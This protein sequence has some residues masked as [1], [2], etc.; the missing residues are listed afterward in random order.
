MEANPQGI[1]VLARRGMHCPACAMPPFATPAEAA[2]S[3]GIDSQEPVEEPR[4]AAACDPAGP[5]P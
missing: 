5:R 2:A 4:A 3:H 1:A